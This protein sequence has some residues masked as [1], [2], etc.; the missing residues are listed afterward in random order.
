MAF[1]KLYIHY[2]ANDTFNVSHS[3][4]LSGW[5]TCKSYTVVIVISII[6]NSKNNNNVVLLK[7]VRNIIK[8][9]IIINV[10]WILLRLWQCPSSL[11][12]WLQVAICLPDNL[13]LQYNINNIYILLYHTHC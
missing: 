9:Y 4:S 10:V 11:P 2:G 12:G 3:T 13:T 6:Q 7:A 5:C 8:K 1:F